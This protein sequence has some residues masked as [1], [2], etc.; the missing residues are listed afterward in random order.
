MLYEMSLGVNRIEGTHIPYGIGSRQQR[1]VVDLANNWSVGV[2]RHISVRV[3]FLRELK[4]Q[5][6]LRV[7]WI[8]TDENSANLFTKN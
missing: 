3:N 8:P 1:G 5:G 6:L 7:M 4:E 2:T